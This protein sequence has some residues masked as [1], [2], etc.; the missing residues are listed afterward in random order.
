MV[1]VELGET[2]DGDVMLIGECGT[3]IG[4]ASG[5]GGDLGVGI[6]VA[7]GTRTYKYIKPIG[8]LYQKGKT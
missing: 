5:R 2:K 4:T 1:Y 8:L 6:G 3:L 7:M